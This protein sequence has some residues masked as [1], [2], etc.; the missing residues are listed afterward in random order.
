M[1]DVEQAQ[2][3]RPGQ[4]LLAAKVLAFL[5]IGSIP[6]A[7]LHAPA[8][9]GLAVACL[10]PAVVCACRAVEASGAQRHEQDERARVRT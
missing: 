10:A 5:S 2:G 9:I 4:Y 6:V 8:A 3:A 1:A 7:L